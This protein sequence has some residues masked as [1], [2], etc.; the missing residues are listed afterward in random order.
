[1]VLLMKIRILIVI[2]LGVLLVV[3]NGIS[4]DAPPATPA[5][6]KKAESVGQ[7][8]LKNEGKEPGWSVEVV[9]PGSEPV[10]E[11]VPD[12]DKPEKLIKETKT[13]EDKS[14]IGEA[15]CGTLKAVRRQGKPQLQ[16][17]LSPNLNLKKTGRMKLL[18]RQNQR[19]KNLKQLSRILTLKKKPSK[20]RKN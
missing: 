7:E 2:I 12:T 4:A 3:A 20:N 18:M 13:G 11:P 19:K 5:T 9:V 14:Q 1:M 17:K 6:D 8:E 15:G 10:S 16:Q